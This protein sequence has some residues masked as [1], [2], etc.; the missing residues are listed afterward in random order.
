MVPE[1]ENYVLRGGQRGYDRLLAL[2]RE[3]W[4][5]TL[6]LFQRAGVSPGRHCVD[7]GCGSGDVT[8]GPARLVAPGGRVTGI[9]MDGVKLDLAR[10]A[11][12]ERGIDHVEFRQ[13][14]GKDWDEPGRYDVS[15]CQVLLVHLREPVERLRRMWAAVR[16]GGLMIVED[17]DF[18]GLCCD[19]PNAA[20][21]FYRRTYPE[22]LRR[23]GGDP[24]SGRKLL[25]Y[26]GEVGASN[27]HVHLV[28]SIRRDGEAK[29]LARSTLESSSDAIVSAGV[30]TRAEVAAA[31]TA[32]AQFTDDPGSSIAGPR[33][34]QVW[35]RR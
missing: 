8:F 6:A 32:L 35:A 5:D 10:R 12:A 22:A 28:Q 13:L 7:V 3:R 18:D 29:S 21:D 2:A 31:V 4:P 25:R 30:A 27:P 23:N 26:F 1:P 24:T 14:N 33:I 34:F 15:Y 20:F 16:P 11:A 19:P 17:A 9:D